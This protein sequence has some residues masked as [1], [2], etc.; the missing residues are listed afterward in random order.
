MKID[1]TDTLKNPLKVP[2]LPQMTIKV[3][4]CP[5]HVLNS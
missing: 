3:Q 1:M 5:T 2:K 4:L